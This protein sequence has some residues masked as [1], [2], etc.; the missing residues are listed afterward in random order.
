[1]GLYDRILI[2]DNHRRLWKRDSGL[3]LDE[4]VREARRRCPGIEVEV[5]VESLQELKAV[6]EAEPDWM[7]LDNM[8]P[9]DLRRCVEL[10][11]ARSRLE[12][13]GGITL[14]SVEETARTGIDAISMG[15]LTHSAPAADLSLEIA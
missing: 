13:S 1:M 12:A 3:P 6:L 7:L 14:D 15:C 5:E 9:K 11:G 8:S 2:K 4:A 10:C